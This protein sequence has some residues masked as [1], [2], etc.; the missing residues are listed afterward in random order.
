M[1]PDTLGILNPVEAYDFC[2]IMI[3]RY[4]E[5]VISIFMPTTIMTWPQ[6]MFIRP[7]G[8]ASAASTPP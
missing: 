8:P 5:S 7:S 3:D 1:L 2:K 6:P 4:P